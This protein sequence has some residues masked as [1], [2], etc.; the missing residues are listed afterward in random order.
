MCLNILVGPHNITLGCCN[1]WTRYVSGNGVRWSR[2][3]HPECKI[4]TDTSTV[5]V[6]S[7]EDG[8]EGWDWDTILLLVFLLL[9]ILFGIIGMWRRRRRGRSMR[10]SEEREEIEM[11]CKGGVEMVET[12]V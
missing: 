10:R 3:F 6:N 12:T 11:K 1:N 8:G 7:V 2:L 5:I 4:S 9:L